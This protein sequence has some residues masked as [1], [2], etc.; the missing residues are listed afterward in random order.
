MA[1]SLALFI[2]GLGGS[3][4]ATW[5]DFPKLIEEDAELSARYDASTFEYSTAMFG[6]APSLQTCAEALG[7]EIETRYSGYSSIALVAHSQ[8]GLIARWHIAHQINSG[9]V[10]R[11]DRLLTFATPHQ[12]AVGASVLSWI[13]GVSRQTKALGPNS[14]FMQALG[15]AWTQAKADQKIATLHVGADSDRIVGPV[16]AK[17]EATNPAVVGGTGHVQVVKPSSSDASSFLV[18]KAFLLDDFRRPSGV[19]AD[20]RPPTLRLNH[21]DMTEVTRF[22]YG[23]RA[24]TFVGRDAELKDIEA[25]L[26]EPTKAFR[27]MLLHGSGGVGKSCLAMELCLAAQEEWH[28]GFLSEDSQE[29]DWTRWRPMAPTLIVIDYAARDTV[30]VGK[31]LRALARRVANDGDVRRLAAPV[32]LILIEQTSGGDW[33]DRIIDADTRALSEQRQVVCVGRSTRRPKRRLGREGAPLGQR[34]GAP[35]FVSLAG[36]EMA[37]LIEMVV[38]LGMN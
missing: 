27:W 28:A 8:G 9:R 1:K 20:S 3:A 4:K 26:G 25:F 19:E 5:L 23:A 10:L 18:A 34:G 24:L 22:V 21:L 7:T 35:L 16:S 32:R 12:G 15:L 31:T 13:P 37:L 11:I 14:E 17:G 36:D 33:L 2:H 38:D 29:P 30:H 6:A